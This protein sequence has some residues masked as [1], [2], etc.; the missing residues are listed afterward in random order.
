FRRAAPK[1]K[2]AV[3]APATAAN[4][5]TIAYRASSSL[6]TQ[7]NHRTSNRTVDVAMPQCG[8]IAKLVFYGRGYDFGSCQK[9]E[10][11]FLTECK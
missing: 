7:F 3:A 10:I 1:S 8:F 4:D 11:D 6:A 9:S 5:A 2:A